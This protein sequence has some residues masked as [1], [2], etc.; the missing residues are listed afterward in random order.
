MSKSIMQDGK[1]CFVCGATVGL[2][3]HHIFYGTSNRKQSEKYGCWCY[4]CLYH[5]TGSNH[6]VHVDKT[7]DYKIKKMCQA[8]LEFT[9]WSREKFI[10]IFG[11]SYLD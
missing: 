11:R 10:E 9:G 1:F 4:L 3:R 2:H 5:H 6:A 8:Q 7:L